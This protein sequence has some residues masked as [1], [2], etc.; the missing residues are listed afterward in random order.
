MNQRKERNSLLQCSLVYKEQKIHHERQG[1]NKNLVHPT[2]LPEPADNKFNPRQ[3]FKTSPIPWENREPGNP[4]HEPDEKNHLG[5]IRSPFPVKTGYSA[6]SQSRA[7]RASPAKT[8]QSSAA[9]GVT[10]VG[11]NTGM[12]NMDA[13]ARGRTDKICHKM[14]PEGLVT[15]ESGTLSCNR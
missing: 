11:K 4:V 12:F 14:L 1:V 10:R 3:H 13:E 9:L 8:P 2:S 15:P 6:A 7:Q 5:W